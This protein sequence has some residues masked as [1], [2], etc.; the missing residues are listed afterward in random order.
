MSS[1]SVNSAAARHERDAPSSTQPSPNGWHTF[2]RTLSTLIPGLSHTELVPSLRLDSASTLSL[3]QRVL[4]RQAARFAFP[5]VPDD[6]LASISTLGE[7]FE[8]LSSLGGCAPS[9][10]PRDEG[11]F[12]NRLDQ[13]PQMSTFSTVLRPLLDADIP[14]LYAAAIDPRSSYRY[15]F[16]GQTPSLRQFNEVL[17]TGVLA[18]FA[19]VDRLS[20]ELRGLVSAYNALPENGIVYIAFHQ[21]DS[22]P[23]S[24][25]GHMMLGMFILIEYLFRTWTFRKVYAELPEFNYDE[26]VSGFGIFHLEGRLKN[27]LYHGNRFWDYCTVATYRDEW[28]RFAQT[29]WPALSGQESPDVD[30]VPSEARNGLTEG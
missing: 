3:S 27:H 8:W 28:A 24:R 7:E 17:Y 14:R 25:R 26:L 30:L 22:T 23:D 9:Y 15:R 29:W 1:L 12:G 10:Q 19:V 20:S 2:T 4:I 6:L 16:R 21:V 13:H 18:Q 11:T 5:T